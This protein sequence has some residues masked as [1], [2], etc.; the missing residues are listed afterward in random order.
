MAHS[1][2][3]EVLRMVSRRLTFDPCL[4]FCHHCTLFVSIHFACILSCLAAPYMYLL[5]LASVPQH[6]VFKSQR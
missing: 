6:M 4:Q 5:F 1:F 2:L 3:M